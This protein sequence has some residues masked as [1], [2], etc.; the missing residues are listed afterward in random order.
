MSIDPNSEL[1]RL[2]RTGVR[3]LDISEGEH[4]LAVARYE[5][6]GQFLAD[7]WASS[8]IGGE[9]TPQGS[10][11]LGTV[12]RNI[13]RHDEI[14]IDLVARRDLAKS[15]ISQ[16]ALKEDTGHGVDLFVKSKPEGHPS[17]EEGKRCWTL[18]YSG[19]HVDIL[20]ALPDLEAGGTGII[21]TDTEVRTWLPSN[22]IGFADWFH[23][24]MRTE[25]TEQ[26]SVLA[27]SM[28]VDQVPDWLV[29]TT[30]QETVQALKRHRDIFFTHDLAN[31]PASIVLTTLA[32]LAYRGGGSLYDVLLDVV[33]T[34]PALVQRHNGLY[35]VSNPVQPKENFADRWRDHP[36]R[37]ERFFVWMQACHT[38]LANLG[39][40]RGVDTVL[41][42]MAK[43]FGTRVAETAERASG[44]GLF[45]SRRA[46]QLSMAAGTGGL[47][48]GAGRAVCPHQFHG[49]PPSLPLGSRSS[50]RPSEFNTLFPAPPSGSGATLWSGRE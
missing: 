46:G 42:K 45:E 8:D 35:V 12:T 19:F 28:N 21:I 2:L 10:M 15:S 9:V 17:K 24:I 31:R 30:L 13:H 49:D 3:S 41:E 34:M 32:V 25:W 5:A 43:A 6:V 26:R 50:C 16:A 36:Y 40:E 1:D 29:K 18:L 14:D 44:S 33:A 23:E 47:V 22:P 20:P 48:T 38:D 7:Y 4:R 39:A 37:A 11:R 27:K